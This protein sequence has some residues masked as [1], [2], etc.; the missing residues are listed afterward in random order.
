MSLALV[1]IDELRDVGS[2]V[3][4]WNGPTQRDFARY[5][6]RLGKP[7]DALTV[8]DLKAAAAFALAELKSL[9]ERGLI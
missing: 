2:F 7:V 1:L 5:I 9:Q 4:G 8:A 6:E 3:D